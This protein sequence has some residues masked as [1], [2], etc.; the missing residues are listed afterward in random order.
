MA[1]TFDALLSSQPAEGQA[2]SPDVLRNVLALRNGQSEGYFNQDTGRWEQAG[3]V[4]TY[5]GQGDLKG[6]NVNETGIAYDT[7]DGYTNNYNVDG[8]Y[9]DRTANRGGTYN[10]M[11][12]AKGAAAAAAMYGGATWLNGMMGGAGGGGL[13]GAGAATGAE[14]ASPYVMD[15]ATKAALFGDAGY[16]AGMS[17]AATSA[18]DAGLAG[19]A[20][21]GSSF[22][23]GAKDVLGSAG[24]FLGSS[25]LGGALGTGLA[26]A[27]AKD[28]KPAAADPML[29]QAAAGL[30]NVG[31]AATNRANANDDY[32]QSTF[33]PRY[34]AAMDQQIADGRELQDFNMGL[35]R[36]YDQRYWDTT[37]RYQDQFYRDV[38]SYNN[39]D[40]MRRMVGQ[41]GATVD[42]QNAGAMAQLSRQLGRMGVNPNSGVYAS[43][44]RQN[45]T[46][47]SL[48]K[49]LAMNMAREAARKEGLN[50]KA[51]AAGLG[52]NLTGAS[53][54]FAGQ[55]AGASGLGMQGIGQA[56]SG[57]NSNNAGW[58]STMG[59]GSNAYGQLGQWGMGMTNAAS[60]ANRDNAM[61][62]NQIIG[63][64]LGMFG[65][66]MWGN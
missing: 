20:G 54:G 64:G 7:G 31:T 59:V 32:W 34:L 1:G 47:G 11:R 26:L 33:A 12:L 23:S 41:A 51:A 62:R 6:Y 22:L 38:D 48:N 40:N 56:Q 28:V 61:G 27:A 58:N 45:A 10:A 43:N 5:Y 3:S 50:L 30:G 24:Q 18:F 65:P 37:A 60:G 49:A 52:G 55:A 8:T 63:T 21:S 4:P 14:A 57:F 16:G 9:R 66:K 17:G 44:M 25:G 19:A 13:S 42:Q 39:E 36:K 46:Q 2:L 53:A 35:A 29:Q 15:S